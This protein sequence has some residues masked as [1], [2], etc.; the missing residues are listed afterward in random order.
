[1]K[2]EIDP[3][4]PR[5]LVVLGGRSTE[6][7]VSIASG[8]NVAMALESLG[9]Q[10]GILDTG[11]GK[12]LQLPELESIQKDPK[13]LP[14]V[15]NLPL[16]D[17]V[18]HFSL[19]FICLHGKFGEDGAF[20]GLLE[21][22]S[23]PYV[24]SR[25]A[26]SSVSMDK[27]LTKMIFNANQIKSPDFKM[28]SSL[29]DKIDLEFP[30]VIKPNNQGSS[31]AVAICENKADLAFGA[32]NVIEQFGEAL[33]EKYIDGQELTVSIIEKDGKPEALPIIEI[34]PKTKFFDFRAKYDG[35]TDEIVPAK[36]SDE[37]ANKVREVALKAFKTLGCRHFARVDIIVNKNKEVFVLEVNTIPGMTLESLFPKS[38]KAAGLSFEQL[39]E[40]LVKIAIRDNV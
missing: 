13:K 22:I 8:H 1:M 14:S 26:A 6:R 3:K 24:G 37:L 18:R 2:L 16:V 17:I 20:Q 12:L 7:E 23:M 32:K 29:D 21:E 35:T 40:H 34:I 5:I 11:T 39:I 38:A 27:R 10:I 36:I 30:V 25:P 28:I 31:V 19:V 4:K 33:V 15:I 9:Y